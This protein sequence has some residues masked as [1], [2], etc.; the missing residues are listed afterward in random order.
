MGARPV[1]RP[2]QATPVVAL[3]LQG[4]GALGAYHI[5]A[6]Q[7][8]AEHNLHPDWVAGISIGAINA[9]IIAGNRPEDRVG[10]LAA[11]WEAISWPDLPPALALTRRGRCCTTWPATPRR[12]CSVSRI[13][14]PCGPVNPYL[15][16]A[17]AGAGSE[18]LRHHAHA[19]HAAAVRGFHADQSPRR[20]AQPGRHQ[21]CHRQSGVLRQ[22]PADDRTGACARQRL[23]AARLPGHAGGRTSST[24]TAGAFPTRR[25]MR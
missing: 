13:F 4:G 7:A 9:A 8:L 20:P 19:V 5:G 10:R 15:R 22:P 2:S 14:S 17:R 11:L 21:P 1:S 3:M 16:P 18:L 24:G 12:C 6:Y 25:W 23:T